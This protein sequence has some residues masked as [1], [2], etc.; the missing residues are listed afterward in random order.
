MAVNELNTTKDT[1]NILS[2]AAFLGNFFPENTPGEFAI[3]HKEPNRTRHFKAGNIEGTIEAARYCNELA[4]NGKDVYFGINPHKDNLSEFQRGTELDIT[5]ITCAYADIDL[6]TMYNLKKG[7]ELCPTPEKALDIINE[8]DI[9]C[10]IVVHSGNG[11]HCYWLL[12]KSYVINSEIDRKKAKKLCVDFTNIIIAQFKTHGYH[13]DPLKDLTRVF[14]VPET[15]NFK[16]GNDKALPVYIYKQTERRYSV[17]EIEEL[18]N[19]QSYL[20]NT[21][22]SKLSI[23]KAIHK[24]S[25]ET[26]LD[27]NAKI[28]GCIL[29]GERNIKLT[30]IAGN[31][32]RNGLGEEAMY[33]SLVRINNDYCQPPLPEQEVWN[34]AKSVSKYYNESVS[35]YRTPGDNYELNDSGNAERF[36]A[37]HGQNIRF[38]PEIGKWLI[39][40]GKYWQID[41][42][43]EITNLA[44]DVATNLQKEANA[45][46]KGTD[47]YKVLKNFAK[48]SGNKQ[49]IVNMIELAKSE[50]GVSVRIYELDND[51]YLLNCQN[52]TLNLKTGLLKQHDRKHLITRCIPVIYEASASCPTFDRFLDDTAGTNDLLKGFFQRIAGYSLT[53]IT[54]EQCLFVF[55]GY[56]ANGKTTLLEVLRALLGD[57]A[58]QME[59]STL[60]A[61]QCGKIRND[62]A[63]I[64]GARFVSVTEAE[65]G[66][67]LSDA[68][69][70]MLTGNDTITAR[71]LYQEYFE[72]EPTHKL[73]LAGNHK[74]TIE[75]IDHGIWRRIHLIPF[76]QTVAPDKRD[77]DLLSKLMMEL[78]GILNWALAG[79]LEW[80]RIGLNPP[81]AVTNA[82]QE[83][84]KE[85]DTVEQFIND[86][87]IRKRH[88]KTTVTSLYNKYTCWC[89]TNGEIPLVVNFFSSQLKA[90]GFNPKKMSNGKARGYEGLKLKD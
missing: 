3:W 43:Q 46:D 38:C 17:E 14:R 75:G 52:G 7:V 19:K 73:F 25:G 33:I 2:M 86:C 18:I 79:C 27:I 74:P 53:G 45:N 70:K 10:T 63:R 34:I 67:K 66:V 39:W 69:I 90:K 65:D 11:L 5:A 23:K 31:F 8:F 48:Q 36:I 68:I 1:A 4:V 78:P 41:Y 47:R 85:M 22:K 44:K 88:A 84:R 9:P 16:A 83:Y 13:I 64:K 32:R 55:F 21:N 28:N 12:D 30:S 60:L 56:G 6:A 35:N 42:T 87:C 61:S 81:N 50:P 82:T 80:R 89:E 20:L 49:P 51:K 29:P 54:N 37:L 26:N 77:P 24:V 62:I 15:Y 76:T 71:F 40:N 59:Y 58:K 57:Y 72:F